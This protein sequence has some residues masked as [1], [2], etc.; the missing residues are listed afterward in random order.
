VL[1][2]GRATT[3]TAALAALLLSGCSTALPVFNEY[4]RASRLTVPVSIPHTNINSVVVRLH[5]Q[6]QSRAMVMSSRTFSN[7]IGPTEWVARLDEFKAAYSGAL[8]SE[9]KK[10]QRTCWVTSATPFADLLMIDFA[11]Q[12]D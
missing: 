8:L 1:H 10:Q 6:D 4:G 7:N 11:I 12:C 9:L 5:P 2:M 3:K